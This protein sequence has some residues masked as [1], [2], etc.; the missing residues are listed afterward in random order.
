[1]LITLDTP[2]DNNVALINDG[3]SER[4]QRAFL[5]KKRIVELLGSFHILHFGVPLEPDLERS[6]VFKKDKQ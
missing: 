4:L 1:M 6:S 2:S 5:R 3:Q